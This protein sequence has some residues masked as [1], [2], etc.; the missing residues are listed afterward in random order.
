M[1]PD[2]NWCAG[3][4]RDDLEISRLRDELTRIRELALKHLVAGEQA[5]AT[6]EALVSVLCS[7]ADDESLQRDVVKAAI[8]V[9]KDKRPTCSP[10][11]GC[12]R[13][14][15]LLHAVDDLLDE[16]GTPA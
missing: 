6:T 4:G 14:C 8:D 5:N 15:T 3:C 9:R 2:H 10:G 11:L 16:K 7:I 12:C 13:F 1:G